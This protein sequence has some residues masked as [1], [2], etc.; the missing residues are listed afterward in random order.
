MKPP[1]QP[2]IA[3]ASSL[4]AKL[5]RS[6]CVAVFFFVAAFSSSAADPTNAYAKWIEPW[7]E[8]PATSPA[9]NG[10][11]LKLIVSKVQGETNAAAVAAMTPVQRI[12]LAYHIQVSAAEVAT[13]GSFRSYVVSNTD[14]RTGD[15]RWLSPNGLWQ[16]DQL[17]SILPDDDAQLPPAGNRIVV[18]FRA[19]GQWHVRVYDGN[20]LPPEVQGVL[21]LL[22]RPYGKLF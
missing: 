2:S 20:N 6:A 5:V 13:N 15:V 14:A 1:G 17:I 7:M 9:L 19:D 18:Q 11:E 3:P 4:L 8:R 21:T 12:Y 16:L 22:A 10:V